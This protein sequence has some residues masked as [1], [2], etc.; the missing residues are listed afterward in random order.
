MTEDERDHLHMLA[1][2]LA[3]ARAV[4]QAWEMTNVADKDEL[5]RAKIEAGHAEAEVEF[6]RAKRK[7][8]EYQALLAAK[9]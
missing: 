3:T 9:D 7:L 8:L 1:A 4:L 2:Q 5:A 6:L